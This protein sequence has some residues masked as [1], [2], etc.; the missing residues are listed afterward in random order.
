MTAGVPEGLLFHV[1]FQVLDLDE[2][3]PRYEKLLGVPFRPPENVHVG[4]VE[5]PF[6]GKP[7]VHTFDARLSY[8]L[9]GPPYYE[10]VE[11][12]GDTLFRAEQGEGLHHIGVW[13]ENN[14][15]FR[16]RMNAEGYETEV[17][18]SVASGDNWCW[19]SVPMG[20]PG[21]RFEFVDSRWKDEVERWWSR[22]GELDSLAHTS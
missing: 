8:S 13:V 7:D 15:E 14:D 20:S 4:G 5:E 17:R 21:V 6:Y 9:D 3:I 16:E 2:A 18:M 10:L 1:C 11:A 19:F 12:F 22:S